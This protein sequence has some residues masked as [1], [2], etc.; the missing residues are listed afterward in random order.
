[1]AGMKGF[2]HKCGCEKVVKADFAKSIKESPFS[3][4]PK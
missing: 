2:V 1:M 3:V 4:T